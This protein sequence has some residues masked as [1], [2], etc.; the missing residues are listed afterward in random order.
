LTV[1]RARAHAGRLLIA[2]EEVRDRTAAEALRGTLIVAD[3]ETSPPT[4][5][6][7]EFWD[8]DLVGLSAVTVEGAPI[9]EVVEVVHL[10]AQDLLVVRRPAD[11][12]ELLVPFVSSIVPT[13]DVAGGRVV[14]DPPPGLFDDDTADD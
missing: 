7:D 10:P 12:A 6:A 13:V 11:E 8:H 9:G 1:A 2:F 14:I 3:S 5:S 4:E